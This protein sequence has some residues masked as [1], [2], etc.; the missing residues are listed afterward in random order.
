MR[1]H[2]KGLD[3]KA[4]LEL[5]GALMDVTPV[6][7]GA[8]DIPAAEAGESESGML[9]TACCRRSLSLCFDDVDLLHACDGATLLG[10]SEAFLNLQIEVFE[11]F[12]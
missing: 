12:A 4:G 2:G 11:N 9:W 6:L 5:V 3:Q 7:D 10:H 1:M 8:R